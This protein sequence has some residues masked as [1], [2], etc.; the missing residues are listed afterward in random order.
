MQAVGTAW[1]PWL[2]ILN[3]WASDAQALQPCDAS[4][5]LLAI[6]CA[7]G[8]SIKGQACGAQIFDAK[9]TR[10]CHACGSQSALCTRYARLH[11]RF[12]TATKSDVAEAQSLSAAFT[13]KTFKRSMGRMLLGAPGLVA[14]ASP[15]LEQAACRLFFF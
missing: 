5:R 2:A 10:Y 3:H 13:V 1:S 15:G 4:R 9:N 7:Q 8:R 6:E 12:K 11:W 14:G